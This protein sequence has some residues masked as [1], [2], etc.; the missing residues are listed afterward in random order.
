[1]RPLMRWTG[2]T[3]RPSAAT[4]LIRGRREGAAPH[5]TVTG[6]DP[7]G[8]GSPAQPTTTSRRSSASYAPQYRCGRCGALA[9]AGTLHFNHD[10]AW[11]SCPS[12][13]GLTRGTGKTI[14]EVGLS[15]YRHGNQHYPPCARPGCGHARGVQQS[16]PP[17]AP[18]DSGC[19]EC[20][21]GAVSR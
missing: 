1:M 20:G 5:R 14:Y 10:C 7:F 3:G 4:D 2:P 17:T 11:G 18:E 9:S 8:Y 6:G 21:V 13:A 12:D 15:A 16:V 19:Y